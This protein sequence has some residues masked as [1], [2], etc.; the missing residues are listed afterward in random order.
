VG[1][2]AGL[3]AFS[4]P[5]PQSLS[6]LK[7]HAQIPPTFNAEE[8]RRFREARALWKQENGSCEEYVAIISDHSNR[9]LGRDL[10]MRVM[11]Q[12]AGESRWW[13]W[14]NTLTSIIDVWPV[15]QEYHRD[16]QMTQ[17]QAQLFL[18]PALKQSCDQLARFYKAWMIMVKRME[19]E[20]LWGKAA[21]ILLVLT[22]MMRA[23]DLLGDDFHSAKQAMKDYIEK[24]KVD[25]PETME[26][27]RLAFFFGL[28]NPM[29]D[30]MSLAAES[31]LFARLESELELE[32]PSIPDPAPATQPQWQ[33]AEDDF[34]G[35]MIAPA[36][37]PAPQEVRS[38][39]VQIAEYR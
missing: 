20:K 22:G 1:F 14:C 37:A 39:A 15:F 4:A 34:V 27:G 17:R 8:D 32:V 11:V 9:M 6:R 23:I 26:L 30:G 3:E 38:I 18:N 31:Q 29:H 12:Q 2:G 33:P 19:S 25:H 21:L 7:F 28:V 36:A 35:R 24:Y 5:F 10:S 16:G 13:T